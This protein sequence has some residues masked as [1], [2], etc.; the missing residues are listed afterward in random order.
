M[1]TRRGHRPGQLTAAKP[2]ACKRPRLIPV[3][4]SAVRDLVDVDDGPPWWLTLRTALSPELVSSLRQ[5]A[6]AAYLPP[7][8]PV[9]RVLD[10]VLRLT[11]EQKR[12]A[13][14]RAASA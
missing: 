11:G 7:H 3:Y 14:A 1:G 4:G 6:V 10:T 12:L 2:V 5:L 9:L 13:V 8:V